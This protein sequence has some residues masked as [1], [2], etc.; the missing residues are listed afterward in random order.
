MA[1]AVIT[2]CKASKDQD[3]VVSV[4]VEYLVTDLTSTGTGILAEALGTS[5]IPSYGDS[6]GSNAN[7]IC[8]GLDVAVDIGEDSKIARVTANYTTL[9]LEDGNYI[10]RCTSSLSEDI[11]NSD[12]N[13]NL[14]TVSYTYPYPYPTNPSLAGLTVTQSPE[15]P[16][17]LPQIVLTATG[18]D[19]VS[20]PVA[21]VADWVGYIN[22]D[23]WQGF[24][25]GCWL[26]TAVPFEAHDLDASPP[27]YKFT[28]EF[29]LNKKGWNQLVQFRDENGDIPS[30]L[31]YGVGRKRIVVQGYKA[32][33]SKF[34]D[35]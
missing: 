26:C 27:T 23:S 28:F 14:V 1:T 30:N 8:R 3:T 5:G 21:V 25:A 15:M 2:G 9:G 11:T 12:A 31:T 17:Q 6:F 18:I 20:K 34:P 7:V 16:V 22:S 32:F 33:G 19:P 35:A 13:G 24:P 4:A 10:F 29:Q